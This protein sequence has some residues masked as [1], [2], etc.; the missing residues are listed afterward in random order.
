MELRQAASARVLGGMCMVE[1][2][3]KYP[4]IVSMDTDLPSDLNA[5]FIKKYPDRA[6]NAGIAEQNAVSVSA[7]L[8]HEGFHPFVFSFTPFLS[9]RACEQVRSD[10]C[11]G[12][13]PVVLIGNGAGYSHGICGA[14]HCGF[15][16]CAIMVSFANMTVL[17]PSEPWML[18]KVLEAAVALKAPVYIRYS[19]DPAPPIYEEG[20][21]YEIGKAIIAR[22]GD[23]GAVIA[24]GP[25]VGF[26]IEAV[27]ALRAEN[28][29]S[30]R[31]VDMHTIKPIDRDAIISAAGT[32]KIVCVQ[33]HS[34]FGGLGTYV[35]QV[36]AEAGISCK[37]KVLGCPD[38]FVPLATTPYLY[39]INEMDAAG[40]AKNMK[41]LL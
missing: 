11:Y 9:M 20:Y 1:L 29:V 31:V 32:G 19:S 26:A 25:C 41:A 38:K 6:F 3:E 13:L 24:S 8:A 18:P 7:G 30:I 27:E 15:E 12:N 14:T 35:G 4:N 23:D 28:G 2:G 39:K 21:K 16:D 37:Y 22:E 34:I 36:I 40:I 10:V 17:E 33:D 5:A